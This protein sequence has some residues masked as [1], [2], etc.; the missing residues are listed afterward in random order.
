M[1]QYPSTVAGYLEYGTDTEYDVVQ[2]S[3]TMD[4]KETRQP[5]DHRNIAAFIKYKS[6]YIINNTSPLILSF[7]L[8]TDVALRSVLGFPCLLAMG[9]VID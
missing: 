9:T 1:T 3:T 5:V 6:P 4:L 2:L 8:G 7:V